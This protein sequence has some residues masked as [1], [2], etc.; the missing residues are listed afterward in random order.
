[1]NYQRLV[2][3]NS[4]M[5]RYLNYMQSQETASIFD[6][7]CGL[8]TISAVV[9]RTTH[10][11]RPRAPVYLNMY[12]VLVGESGVARKTT[13][14]RVATTVARSVIGGDYPIGLLDAKLT[15]E[16]L[17]EMLHFRTMEHGSA[18]LAVAVT[19]L[20]VLL[21][22]ERYTAHMPTLLTDLYDCPTNREGGATIARGAIA[23]RNVWIS[24]LSA[25]TP[26][27]LLK[28][29][30][31]SVVEGGFTSRC[32]FIISNTPKKRIPWPV[33]TDKDLLQDIKDDAKIIAVEAGS[34][35]PI[36]MDPTGLDV[37]ST[38]YNEKDH[39]LDPFKQSFESREDAHVLRLAALL[40]INDG[41]WIIKRSHVNIAIRLVKDIKET[42]GSI[43]ENAEQ[44][45]KY[46]MA[47]DVIRAQLMSR[48]MDPIP[49]GAL[50]RKCKNYVS[51]DEFLSL[52]EVLHEIG[53]IQRFM[54]Q[55]EVGRPTDFI[56]GTNLILSRGLGET[57][58]DRFT[59]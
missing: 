52:I 23:Q 21:G 37:F 56:R 4:F 45:T 58:M 8:W 53:A 59:S 7:Y 20:A 19:E 36:Q 51:S 18:Q 32:Y 14:I 24:L 11:D 44:R 5:G 55:G 29:V 26:V 10:V 30:N 9:G 54:I 46:A 57:V 38:W 16:K 17:D 50:Y 15:P 40:C 33:E 25:S 12:V 42:A 6:F 27:W 43:F 28:T 34:R 13:S 47:L 31:P 3:P 2:P 49:R 41:S 22:T 35:G 39:A 48:G 1:M